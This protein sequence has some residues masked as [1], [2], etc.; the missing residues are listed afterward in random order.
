MKK[1]AVEINIPEPNIRTLKLTLVGT[2]NL[3]QHRFSE[4]AKRQIL[5]KQMKKASKAKEARN[6]KAEF[7]NALYIIKDGKFTY[8]E[9]EGVGPV[10]FTG[11]VGIPALWIKQAVVAAARNVDDLP[12]VLL[13]GAVFVKGRDEDGLIPLKYKQ[14]RMAEHIVRIGRGTS[15]LRFRGEFLGWEADVDVKFNADV[16]SA[17]QVVNLLKIGG[18]SCGL[19]EWRPARNGEFGTFDVKPRKGK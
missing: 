5:D 6:P 7:E 17:E 4:K 9:K 18:F 10:K 15:D 12:M 14:L 1:A 13:R 2:A 8:A 3:L 11:E 19:G 16:L